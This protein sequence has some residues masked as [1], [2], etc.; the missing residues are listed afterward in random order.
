MAIV[1]LSLTLL[2]LAMT[3]AMSIPKGYILD[4]TPVCGSSIRAR[5]VVNILT[6]LNI[7]AVAR[8]AKGDMNFTK[9]DAANYKLIGSYVARTKG[10]LF[11]NHKG[12]YKLDVAI[13]YGL[14]RSGL[15]ANEQVYTVSCA[16]NSKA[17]VTATRHNVVGGLVSPHEKLYN[18]GTSVSSSYITLNVQDIRRKTISSSI[19]I[20]KVVTLYAVSRGT[21]RE[22]GLRA[23]SCYGIGAVNKKKYAILRAGCGDGQVI[24]L[25]AGFITTGR[26]TRSPYF[27]SFYVEGDRLVSYQCTF[28]LC[29]GSCNGSSCSVGKNYVKG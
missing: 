11:V 25:N 18:V 10:C 26:T 14:P 3:S 6:D 5:P 23:V 16:F 8:C 24:P 15:L 29:T 12:I 4:V 13:M 21:L 19:P 2:S 7:R 20:D 27:R 1:I 17:K 9:L 22:R 28:Q